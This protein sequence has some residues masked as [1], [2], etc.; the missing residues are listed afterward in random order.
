[1]R[2]LAISLTLLAA[3]AWVTTSA[4]AKS[5]SRPAQ[6]GSGTVTK[7]SAT[8]VYVNGLPLRESVIVK[9]GVTY[10]PLRAVS[11]SLGCQV[12]WDSAGGGQAPPR[13]FIWSSTP[14][15]PQVPGLSS[16]QG[17]G[18]QPFPPDP[19]PAIPQ[20]PMPGRP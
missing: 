11:E 20:A 10:V 2:Y 7:S 5:S 9:D 12:T 3:A 18:P 17:A 14:Q 16:D 6:A 4:I 1:M 8:R 19:R 13:V 15:V